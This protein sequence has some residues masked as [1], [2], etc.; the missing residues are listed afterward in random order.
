MS[1]GRAKA[2][3]HF[4]FRIF[5]AEL[6]SLACSLGVECRRN[7][8][9]SCTHYVCQSKGAGDKELKVAKDNGCHLVSPHWIYE[10]SHLHHE[11]SS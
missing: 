11:H 8:D 2:M 5:A 3:I 1:K 9:N 4:V 6:H 10:V 7:V